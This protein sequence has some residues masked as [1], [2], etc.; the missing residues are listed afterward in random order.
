MEN[1]FWSY[2]Y[3]DDF[4]LIINPNWFTQLWKYYGHWSLIVPIGE[5]L[6]PVIIHKWASSLANWL[7]KMLLTDCWSF[8]SSLWLILCS[9]PCFHFDP[10]KAIG[11]SLIKLENTLEISNWQLLEWKLSLTS[12]RSRTC[13]YFGINQNYNANSSCGK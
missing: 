13:V 10:L 7:T 9:Q 4:T 5:V 6:S 1:V 12:R 2:F 11:L 8:S 3:S